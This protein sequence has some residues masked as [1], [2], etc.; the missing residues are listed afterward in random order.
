MSINIIQY[1]KKIKTPPVFAR[2]EAIQ[3]IVEMKY[4]HHPTFLSKF[5]FS[6]M[7][8]E[9]PQQPQRGYSYVAWDCKPHERNK[10]YP[11]HLRR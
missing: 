7:D 10:K 9:L 6:V 2:N 8:I 3:N 1:E 4:P 11:A 5:P